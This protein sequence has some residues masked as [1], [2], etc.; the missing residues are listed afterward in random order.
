MH[1]VYVLTGFELRISSQVF[2]LDSSFKLWKNLRFFEDF[3]SFGMFVQVWWQE[4]FTSVRLRAMQWVLQRATSWIPIK[5]NGAICLRRWKLDWVKVDSI[6]LLV[7]HQ[8]CIAMVQNST[9]LYKVF[10]PSSQVQIWFETSQIGNNFIENR[11]PDHYKIEFTARYKFGTRLFTS[12][13]QDGTLKLHPD[14]FV[15]QTYTLHNGLGFCAFAIHGRWQTNKFY[16]LCLTW[17]YFQWY[18]I[19]CSI[20]YYQYFLA[21]ETASSTLI[22]LA[23]EREKDTKFPLCI[24]WKEKRFIREP[25]LVFSSL[26]SWKQ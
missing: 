7:R 1:L 20:D 12:Y 22:K 3:F 18:L 8:P 13:I 17:W 4:F 5:F 2:I 23:N 14:R 19:V 26:V 25:F 9:A 10:K 21:T 6:L 11:I 16:T 15:L 24:A